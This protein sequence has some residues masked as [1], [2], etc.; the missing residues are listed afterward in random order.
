MSNP[1]LMIGGLLK[2]AGFDINKTYELYYDIITNQI[3]IKETVHGRK[4]LLYN[5]LPYITASHFCTLFNIKNNLSI[6]DAVKYQEDMW[7]L[8][9]EDKKVS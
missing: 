1:K 8:Q 5:K 4:V 6:T 3:G 9:L 7:I 2:N